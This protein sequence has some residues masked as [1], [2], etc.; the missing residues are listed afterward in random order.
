MQPGFKI[1]Q[2]F[3]AN[4]GYDDIIIQYNYPSMNVVSTLP[5]NSSYSDVLCSNYT[6]AIFKIKWK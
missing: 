2:F 1:E 3:N 6:V 4:K 5:A